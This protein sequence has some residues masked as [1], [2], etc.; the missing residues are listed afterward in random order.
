M[1]W[2]VVLLFSCVVPG[3]DSFSGG[4]TPGEPTGGGGS[5]GGNGGG[6][7]GGGT[8]DTAEPTG[9]TVDDLEWSSAAANTRDSKPFY[10]GDTIILWGT[11]NNPCANTVSLTLE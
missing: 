1:R 11:A 2:I 6:D 10:S 3:D 9:C 5:S 8:G 4:G 7:D